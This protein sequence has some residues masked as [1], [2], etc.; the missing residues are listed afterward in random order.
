MDVRVPAVVQAE[1]SLLTDFTVD[2]DIVNTGSA[3]ILYERWCNWR[4]EQLINGS[5]APAYAPLCVAEAREIYQLWIGERAVH[6]YPAHR[7][8]RVGNGA[9]VAGTY[10]VLL[11]VFSGAPGTAL[12]DLDATVVV[13]NSFTVR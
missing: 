7:S 13:S 11:T 10:R 8:W 9:Q 6:R 12:T 2:A 3:T 1:L 4:I 5:W